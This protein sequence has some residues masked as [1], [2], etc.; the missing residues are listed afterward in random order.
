VASWR[1]VIDIP[2]PEV[3]RLTAVLPL[4]LE[5]ARS[6]R[7]ADGTL[8]DPFNDGVP[9]DLHVVDG[10]H[11]LVGARYEATYRSVAV[12]GLPDKVEDEPDVESVDPIGDDWAAGPAHEW[13]ATI[14]ADDAT[15]VRVAVVDGAGSDD[16]ITLTVELPMPARP[17]EVRLVGLVPVAPD[18]FM[19]GDIQ[20]EG[21][22][23]W[24]AL[25]VAGDGV[26]R[27]ATVHIGHP[28]FR[29]GVVADVDPTGATWRVTADGFVSGRGLS[30]PW[31]ALMMFFVARKMRPV[32]DRR[33]AELVEPVEEWIALTREFERDDE[34]ADAL[35]DRWLDHVRHT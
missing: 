29:A 19:A 32:L 8:L 9:L 3:H 24:E 13:V 17:V 16:E 35:V 11:P 12:D 5:R 21:S 22:V 1:G 27:L 18:G 25:Q 31:F 6:L 33:L 15:A 26:R 14:E 2:A 7:V 30:W 20:A 23:S 4:V 28:R 34:L 10:V